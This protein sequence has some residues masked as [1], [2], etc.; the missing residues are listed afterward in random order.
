MLTYGKFQCFQLVTD[1][2][3]FKSDRLLGLGRGGVGQGGVRPFG[4]V[5]FHLSGDDPLGL[6]A[7]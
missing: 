7:V 5:E 6:E 3:H 1:S 4:I 2:L